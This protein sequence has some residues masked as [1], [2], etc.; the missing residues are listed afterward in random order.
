MEQNEVVPGVDTH[1]DTHIGTVIGGTGRLLRTLSVT[2][3]TED[4]SALLT[5]ANSF[6]QL[7]RAGVE[8]TGAYGAGLARVLRDHEIE[9]PEVNRPD[10]ATRRSKENQVPRMPERLRVPSS[11]EG[12]RLYQK[13]SL[14]PQRQ[15]VQSPSLDTVPSRP[16]RRL[17]ISYGPCL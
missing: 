15:C 13:N 11:P 2:T 9:A 14:V 16:R 12:Q 7:R 10:R 17:S 3:D 1:F 5:W 6:G 8:G 4:I